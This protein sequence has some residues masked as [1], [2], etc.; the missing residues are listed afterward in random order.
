V[1]GS[2]ICVRDEGSCSS[3]FP[4]IHQIYIL[5]IS[6]IIECLIVNTALCVVTVQLAVC[7]V[8]LTVRKHKQGVKRHGN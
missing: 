6:W 7:T 1:Q 8:Q 3:S 4:N 2:R 5:R